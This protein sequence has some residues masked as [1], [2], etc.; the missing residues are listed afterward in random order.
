M[1]LF[2]TTFADDNFTLFHNDG[3]GLFTDI[4]YPSGLGEPTIPFL[5]W[6]TFFFD[7]NNNGWKDLF[8]VNGHVYPEVEQL[9]KDMRYLQS[10]LLFENLGN[11]K[12]QDVS[13][14]VGL[15]EFKLTGRGGAYGDYDNDGDLDVALVNMDDHPLIL[16][17][18]G[19][20]KLGHWLQLKT[21][22]VK[23]NR[24]GIGAL[25]KV[26]VDGRTQYD[27]VRC[28]GN[29]LSG[30]DMRLH[31]GLGA[32]LLVNQIEIQWP[33]GVVDRL[34]DVKADQRVV[35]QEGKGQFVGNKR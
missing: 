16:R 3:N 15:A 17:N 21:I 8:C 10:P 31:F 19:G 13:Q 30:N 6:A 11:R 7:Y 18:Q 12:F 24:D 5:G 9:F 27:R 33:S 32:S 14:K 35:V 23:S 26:V 20:N 29:Y 4:S 34:T 2:I 22:G 28:G 1:E 25:V